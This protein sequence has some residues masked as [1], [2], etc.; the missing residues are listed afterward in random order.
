MPLTSRLTLKAYGRLTTSLDLSTSQNELDYAKVID[1]GNGTGAGQADKV[2]HDTRTLNASA[3]ETLDL[4]GSLA[5]ALG[6]PLSFARIKAL[7]V[8]A[9]PTNTHNVLVGGA[10]ANGWATWVGD[11]TDV[12]VVRPGGF[13]ALSASDAT[14]YP[15]TAATGDLLKVANSGGVGPVTYDVIILGASA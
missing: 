10:A 7:I 8:A 13:L 4:A 11:P 15:V 5:D 14:A 2:F 6:A 1:L 3:S 9:A 12:I